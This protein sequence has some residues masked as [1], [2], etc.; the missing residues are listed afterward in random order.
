MNHWDPSLDSWYKHA[1]RT[2]SR[3]PFR[4]RRPGY[5]I[6]SPR[7]WGNGI[8][9]PVREIPPGD[10]YQEHQPNLLYDDWWA[11]E[12]LIRGTYDDWRKGRF[13]PTKA[14]QRPR[15]E[16]Q[17][18][19]GDGNHDSEPRWTND[20]PMGEAGLNNRSDS[21]LAD[22]E[23]EPEKATLP[24]ELGS[25]SPTKSTDSERTIVR[26]QNAHNGD[27]D[28]DKGN[29]GL[30]DLRESLKALHQCLE[31][32]KKEREMI[33]HERVQLVRLRQ[34]FEQIIHTL[35][36]TKLGTRRAREGQDHGYSGSHAVGG[37]PYTPH[38]GAA[39]PGP[40]RFNWKAPQR[41]YETYSEE[42][43]YGRYDLKWMQAFLTELADTGAIIDI[44]WP[45]PTLKMEK[46]SEIPRELRH[47]F[48][49]P[50]VHAP[51]D[52]LLRQWNAFT[53]FLQ[54]FGLQACEPRHY[55]GKT[56]VRSDHRCQLIFDI[57][58]Q[59]AGDIAKLER[60]KAKLQDEKKRW[61]PDGHRR[62]WKM[63]QE[64]KE[65]E[66]EECAK[67]VFNAVV[68]ASDACGR[69]LKGVGGFGGFHV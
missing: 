58:L 43:S 49:H 24:S 34:E 56:G 69:L 60:L 27:G 8:H 5:I 48:Q 47:C 36:E 57:E 61:H 32:L 2:D 68:N 30:E 6:E 62:K 40:S 42:S 22:S 7:Y 33:H 54:G 17:Y 50:A 26:D 11:G 19:M 64:S 9:R 67:A 3:H 55:C 13:R 18:G 29:H 65:E 53:F 15:P 21:Y 23:G 52:S 66:E 37:Y 1:T 41:R 35:Y 12:Y 16:E 39:K 38:K 44:P 45:T 28:G 31:G 20:V 63:R 51:G 25:K 14:Q 4:P 10:E 46:L 59:G